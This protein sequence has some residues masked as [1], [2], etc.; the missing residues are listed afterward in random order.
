LEVN[1]IDPDARKGF[2]DGVKSVWQ[3]YVDEGHFTWD[4]INEA[5]AIAAKQ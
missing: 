3:A 2:V 1:H 4:E 5:L